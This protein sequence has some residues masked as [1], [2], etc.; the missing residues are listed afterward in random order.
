MGKLGAGE[1][2]YA[3]DI[4]LLL[5]VPP[6]DGEGGRAVD[7]RPFLEVARTAWRVDLDLRPEGR[8]G[9]LARSL[10][11]YEGYWDRWAETWEFQ[12]LLKARWV[13]GDR[14]LGEQFEQ[15]AAE[16][17]WHRPFGP[18]EVSAVR[19][20]KTRAEAAVERGGR[21]RREL[22]GGPG[23]IRDIEFAVQLL[24]LVH[25]QEDPELRERST[26]A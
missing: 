10:R 7:V 2:N 24:Q 11:S 23:G 25:G 5:V 9:A 16:R 22:K 26:V 3:S 12:A 4:D 20:M 14:R 21:S 17:V 19:R 1:L 13:A 15:A 18:E 8:A 6:A